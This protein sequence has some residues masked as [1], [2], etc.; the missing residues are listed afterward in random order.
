MILMKTKVLTCVFMNAN[1]NRENY[2]KRL[3][4][5]IL[6]QIQFVA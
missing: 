2:T 1:A 6:I 4:V 3:L 5:V